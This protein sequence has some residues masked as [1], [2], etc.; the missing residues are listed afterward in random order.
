MQFYI[1][2]FLK[3]MKKRV[4]KKLRLLLTLCIMVLLF[5]T[6]IYI[7]YKALEHLD[8]TGLYFYTYFLN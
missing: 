4:N 7:A 3:A 1:V 6:H 2:R 5:G 8:I